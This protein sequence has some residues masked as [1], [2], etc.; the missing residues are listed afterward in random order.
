MW[1][2]AM[3]APFLL[4]KALVMLKAMKAAQEAPKTSMGKKYRISSVRNTKCN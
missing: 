2:T 4:A 1:E 3:D